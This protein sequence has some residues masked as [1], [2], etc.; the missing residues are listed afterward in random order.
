[1]AARANRP[2]VDNIAKAKGISTVKSARMC[3]SDCW[4]SMKCFNIFIYLFLDT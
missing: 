3:A 4:H 2:K 1:M